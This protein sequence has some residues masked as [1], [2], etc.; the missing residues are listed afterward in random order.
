[1]KNLF[2][3]IPASF[4]EEITTALLRTK[5][6]RLERIVSPPNPGRKKSVPL[7]GWLCQ[8]KPEWVIL[9]Q[10]SAGL[11]FQKGKTVRTLKPGD[12]LNIPAKVIHRVEWTD[13]RKPTVWLALHYSK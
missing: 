8:D 6:F 1:M 12:Y 4:P 11:R 13:S 2:L 7:T 9:L 5:S 3:R 10:G